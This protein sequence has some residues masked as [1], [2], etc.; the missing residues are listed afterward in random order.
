MPNAPL[1][2]T[3]LVHREKAGGETNCQNILFTTARKFRPGTLEVF[4]DGS[5]LSPSDDFEEMPNLMS[6]QLKISQD[7][8]R[9]KHPPEDDEEIWV[10][11]VIG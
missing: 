10:K 6:F 2:I 5:W 11:Y 8:N 4:L 9:L 3:A 1:L 7:A